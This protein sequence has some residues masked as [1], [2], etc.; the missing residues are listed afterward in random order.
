MAPPPHDPYRYVTFLK[1]RASHDVGAQAAAGRQKRRARRPQWHI[2]PALPPVIAGEGEAPAQAEPA[3]QP[4]LPSLRALPAARESLGHAAHGS[5]APSDVTGSLQQGH[6]DLQFQPAVPSLARPSGQHSCPSIGAPAH[7]QG[8]GALDTYSGMQ[9]SG[10]PQL[11]PTSGAGS[12][13]STP[14]PCQQLPGQYLRHP[15]GP[16]AAAG[17][18][19]LPRSGRA[20]LQALPWQNGS[21]PASQDQQQPTAMAQ[22][23]H[24]S[25]LCDSHWHGS[26]HQ[27][28]HLA[29]P[30]DWAGRQEASLGRAGAQPRRHSEGSWQTHH[31]QPTGEL[32]HEQHS[33]QEGQAQ[34]AAGHRSFSQHTPAAAGGCAVEQHGKPLRS[35]ASLWP[36]SADVNSQ[37]QNLTTAQAHLGASQKPAS[38]L[39]ACLAA[40]LAHMCRDIPLVEDQEHVDARMQQASSEDHWTH[41]A[42]L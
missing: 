30:A 26:G 38:G 18:H 9:Q 23:A 1:C 22:A 7:S 40:A 28:A 35:G 24:E 33:R 3:A 27:P 42:C 8:P 10:L 21:R 31:H 6:R 34:L 13:G 11:P 2:D 37:Q 20:P 14:R 15:H 29:Q 17:R 39:A 12:P 36:Q 41:E 4:A 5:A 32:D 16:G 19:L 25:P